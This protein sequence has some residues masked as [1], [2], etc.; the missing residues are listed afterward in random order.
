MKKQLT[1]I[2]FTTCILSLACTLLAIAAI[3]STQPI[4]TSPQNC[5][6]S[7][8]FYGVGIFTVLGMSIASTTMYFNLCQSIKTNACY[9]L[10][11]FLLLP[12]LVAV[13]LIIVVGDFK[14]AWRMDLAVALPFLALQLIQFARFRRKTQQIQS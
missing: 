12:L 1:I 5:D 14:Y 6:M 11:S 10:L 8:I 13:T 7:G 2:L 3:F 4:S 9:S